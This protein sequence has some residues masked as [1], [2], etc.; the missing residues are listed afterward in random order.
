MPR[1]HPQNVPSFGLWDIL[2]L[3]PVDVLWTSPFRTFEYLFSSRKTEMDVQ[4]K[5]YCI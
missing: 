1:R 3:G 5:E 2:Q 4:N